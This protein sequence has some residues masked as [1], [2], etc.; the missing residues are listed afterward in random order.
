MGSVA[1]EGLRFKRFF[2][3]LLSGLAVILLLSIV[4]VIL[5]AALLVAALYL[6]YR[7]MVEYGVDPDTA[8]WITLGGMAVVIAII[9]ATIMYRVSK[10]RKLLAPR[11]PLTAKIST[12]I[13]HMAEAFVDGFMEAPERG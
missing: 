2:S 6:I 11:L 13:E 12:T 7:L 9:I 5:A 10:L 1:M 8:M 3:G 4:V